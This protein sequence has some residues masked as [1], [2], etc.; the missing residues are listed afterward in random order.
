MLRA[1]ADPH[2]YE[3]TT[4]IVTTGPY[5]VTRNPMYV[6]ATVVYV[7]IAFV[8]N[9]LWPIALLPVGIALLYYGVIARE[10]RYM[11]KVFGD[12]YLKYKARVRRWV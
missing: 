5:A 10:E 7:G 4:A 8:V 9:T 3:P 1:G 2:P 12:E 11:E 6:F